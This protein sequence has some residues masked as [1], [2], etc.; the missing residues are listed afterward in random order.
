VEILVTIRW[1][2]QHHVIIHDNKKIHI[3]G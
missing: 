1:S 3:S 2:V